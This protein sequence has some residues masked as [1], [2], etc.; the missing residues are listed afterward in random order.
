MKPK[1]KRSTSLAAA[2]GSGLYRTPQRIVDY[3]IANGGV[4]VKIIEPTQGCGAFLAQAISYLRK[5][6]GMDLVLMNPPF[7]AP[8]V[9]VQPRRRT[10]LADTTG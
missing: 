10:P 5:R 3:C 2:T 1:R 4:E 7:S 6:E 9:G 8:N